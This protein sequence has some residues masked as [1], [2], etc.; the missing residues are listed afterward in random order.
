MYYVVKKLYT[1]SLL[2][3]KKLVFPKLKSKNAQ[4]LKK[5]EKTIDIYSIK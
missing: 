4:S 5:K 2:Q 3:Q 1:Q